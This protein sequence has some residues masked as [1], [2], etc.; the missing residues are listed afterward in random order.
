MNMDSSLV[1][2]IA[3]RSRRSPDELMGLILG[4]AREE[5]N[6][7]GFAGATTKAIASRAG[8]TEA[9][10]FRYFASK[11]D[12]FR[13]AVFTSL[14][15]HFAEFQRQE[16]GA[17]PAD[18][19]VRA[20]ARE[21]IADLQD[22]LRSDGQMLLALMVAQIFDPSE[23]PEAM[24]I[25]NLS[26]YFRSGAETLG[27]RS[28]AGARIDPKIMVRISF[29]AVLATSLFRRW[30][31]PHGIADDAEIDA[32]TIDFVIE[33]IAGNQA[34]DGPG[35]WSGD[36]GGRADA[37]HRRLALGFVAALSA[38]ELPDHLL[39]DDFAAWTTSARDLVRKQYQLQ[40][41]LRAS[42]FRHCLAF[43]IDSVVAAG[44]RVVVEAHGSGELV[45]GQAFESR[46]VFVLRVAEGRIAE[47]AEHFDP[48]PVRSRLLPLMKAV[49][50]D[51]ES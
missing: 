40:V 14:N 24:G 33:G 6:R 38:G 44:E 7:R 22:Y 41:R 39:A 12:L 1:T 25:D 28:G 51:L 36:H 17:L 27:A 37:D 18:T 26:E 10:L 8:V 43:A 30:L 9:Q 23:A 34:P 45:N 5:F 15:R 31:F 20:L 4:A 47:V 19:N 11:T 42:V 2:S 48:E 16:V 32:A 46:F 49:I 13:E 29:A 50:G 21:Y 3:R 35:I